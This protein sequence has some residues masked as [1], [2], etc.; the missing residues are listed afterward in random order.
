[1]SSNN[2]TILCIETAN[3]ITS[4][5]IAKNGKCI[6]TKHVLEPNKAADTLQLQLQKDI[7]SH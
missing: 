3:S 4:V 7:V 5:A 6:H 1:M 2:V